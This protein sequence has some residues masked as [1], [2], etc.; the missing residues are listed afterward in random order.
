MIT[1]GIA[2]RFKLE[3]VNVETGE[4][5]ELAPWFNNLITD[6]GLNAWGTG[7]ILGGCVVGTGSTTPA[8]SDT[9]LATWRAYSNTITSS[10]LGGQ[11]TVPY[12]SSVTRVYRF[13]AGTATG[14]LTELGVC[15]GSSTT[16]LFSRTL[17]K[18]GSGNPTTITVLASEALDVT[19]ELRLY[20]PSADVPHSTV[21]AGVTYTGVVRAANVTSFVSSG[22]TWYLGNS[23]GG[24]IDLMQPSYSARVG[25]GAIGA[26]TTSPGGTN[27]DVGD[28][29]ASAYSNGSLARTGTLTLGLSQGNVAGGITS[30]LIPTKLGAYQISFSPAVPKDA[31]KVLTLGLTLS[32]ARMVI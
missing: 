29:V 24:A 32:W 20:A 23:M 19:Y 28:V 22:Y 5:R 3:A 8:V 17:I 6:S 26:A 25:N 13:A 27:V 14:N 15:V 12:Y 1:A 9:A 2:G 30:A 10:V 31:T 21:I 18:D 4:R 11:A 7:G 16:A